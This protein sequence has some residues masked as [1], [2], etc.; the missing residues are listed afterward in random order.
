MSDTGGGTDLQGTVLNF[1][2]SATSGLP[3]STAIASGIYRP[4]NVGT[5]DTFPAPAPASPYAAS[6]TVF[7]QTS[8][9]GTWQ[10][11]VIDDAGQD[12]G[13]IDNG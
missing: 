13:A 4:T 3:D 8:P 5:G 7:N 2:N 1:Q 10:L 12:S 6:L 11:F 9:N